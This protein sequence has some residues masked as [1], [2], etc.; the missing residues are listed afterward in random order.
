[1]S[2]EFKKPWPTCHL[3]VDRKKLLIDPRSRPRVVKLTQPDGSIFQKLDHGVD[4]Q[5]KRWKLL[6]AAI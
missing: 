1:M 6:K 4:E 5:A 3:D 2:K